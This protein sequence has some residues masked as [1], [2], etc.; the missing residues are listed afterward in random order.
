MKLTESQLIEM[1]RE[2]AMKVISEVNKEYDD[3]HKAKAY[4]DY[5]GQN[6][7]KRGWDIVTGKR[8]EKPSP[9]TPNE[10]MKA[11]A[12]RYVDAFNKSHGLGKRIDYDNGESYHSGM[13]WSNDPQ[14][15]YEPIL[16]QT[17][18]DG[19]TIAQQRKAYDEA[20][21]E[22]EWGIKYPYSEAGYTGEY[23]GDNEDIRRRS[24]EFKKLRGEVS[25]KLAA[26][27]RE[28]DSKKSKKNESVIRISSEDF[29]NLI[30]ESVKDAINEIINHK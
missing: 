15:R 14:N 6:M 25:G 16:S 21:N 26:S 8:P 5:L 29:H 23:E 24:G 22:K 18:Y 13:D 12:Q 28:R 27:K 4:D 2:S 17:A 9:Y 7:F 30:A 19:A 11:R 10:P 1:I 3:M 20:G